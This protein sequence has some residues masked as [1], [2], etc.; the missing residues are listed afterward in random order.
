MDKKR[1]IK[2]FIIYLILFLIVPIALY[3]NF[4]I[5]KKTVWDMHIKAWAIYSA[6]IIIGEIVL[7]ILFSFTIT[8]LNK[9]F[10]LLSE[11]KK[12]SKF[13]KIT[14]IAFIIGNL[15]FIFPLNSKLFLYV[16]IFQSILIFVFLSIYLKPKIDS[17]RSLM[18]RF[19]K[20]EKIKKTN[21]EKVLIIYISIIFIFILNIVLQYYILIIYKPYIKSLD[22][23]MPN[24]YK[25]HVSENPYKP[26]F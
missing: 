3:V 13:I 7:M 12:I 14:I 21:K 11:N 15:F 9:K 17:K 4:F 25:I 10:N 16:P 24:G 18:D 26:K 2:D 22:Y 8:K 6:L 1:V 23:S 20:L 19:F 5:A